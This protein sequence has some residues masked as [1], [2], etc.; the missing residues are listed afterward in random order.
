MGFSL[1]VNE[2]RENVFEWEKQINKA[3]SQSMKVGRREKERERRK[4]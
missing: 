4:V 1:F 2:Q 3:K